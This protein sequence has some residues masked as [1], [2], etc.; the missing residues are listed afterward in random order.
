MLTAIA[1]AAK[2]NWGYPADWM[3][4]WRVELTITPEFIAE[5]ATFL[6][7]LDGQIVGFHALVEEAES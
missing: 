2:A 1:W 4:Q 5:N 6:A 3:E 7:D